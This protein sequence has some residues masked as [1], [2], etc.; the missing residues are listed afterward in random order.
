MHI[1][2][3]H[4]LAFVLIAYSI[5]LHEIAHGAAALHYGD[6]TAKRLGRLSLNPI[7]HI[8]PIGTILFP[9]L[10]LLSTG[11]VFLGWARPVPVNPLNL[12]PRVRGDVAVALA[13]V[14]VNLVLA[15][16]FA[17]ALGVLG[18]EGMGFY[19]PGRL[20]S[21]LH[22]ALWWAMFANVALAIF[23]LLPIPP[24]DGSHVAKYLLPP[25]LR[26]SYQ[27]LGF[28]GV[29]ILLLLIMT[30]ALDRVLYPP[31]LF[32]LDQLVALAGATARLLGHA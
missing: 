32:L 30:N 19:A 23:N 29:W 25:A 28:Y 9:L 24:L 6:P 5:I 15:A 16:L 31:V 13:G 26:A 1:N 10:Q 2:A 17:L 22:T 12:E 8:D 14:A 20:P 7:S 27:R 21:G 4:I 18:S 11:H 3:A